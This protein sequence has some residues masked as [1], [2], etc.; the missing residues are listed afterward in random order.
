MT[1]DN[2][3]KDLL[4]V[5]AY[6]VTQ[7][8]KSRRMTQDELAHKANID[9]TYIGYIENARHNVSVAKL[10]CIAKA[11]DIEVGQLFEVKNMY[12]GTIRVLLSDLNSK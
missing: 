7:I 12:V 9:R 4:Q 11:L 10:V 1:H 3:V 5:I 6:N 2:D 8:R